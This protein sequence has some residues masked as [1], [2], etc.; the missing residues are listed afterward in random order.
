[1][2]ADGSRCFLTEVLGQG[3]TL[4]TSGSAAHIAPSVS[5]TRVEVGATQAY[6][7]TDGLLAQRYGLTPGASYL[8]RPDGHVAARFRITTDDAVIQ[9][10]QKARGQ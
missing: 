5:L 6:Q 8:I 10:Y 2:R 3:F 9:A 7:D 1:M 4:L